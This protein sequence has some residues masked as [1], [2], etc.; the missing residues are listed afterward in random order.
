MKKSLALTMFMGLFFVSSIF[1]Q[2]RSSLITYF[3]GGYYDNYWNDNDRYNDSQTLVRYR[4]DN[5]L[6]N[7]LSRDDR[8][9]LK[10]LERKLYDREEC[11]WEDGYISD[12]ERRRV[13]EVE[14]DI[15]K[16]LRRYN[17]RGYRNDNRYRDDRRR[18]Q[19]NTRRN[20]ACWR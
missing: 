4:R 12:R 19:R 8:R 10:R 16:L 5:Y 18:S 14:R 20:A 2:R 1:S 7:R 9:R 13:R 3:N 6:F 11:A 17:N 15:Y